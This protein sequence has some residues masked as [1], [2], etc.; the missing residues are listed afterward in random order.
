MKRT[1]HPLALKINIEVLPVNLTSG[2]LLTNQLLWCGC[3]GVTFYSQHNDSLHC[4]L[5]YSFMK[6][7]IVNWKANFIKKRA[8]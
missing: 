7:S 2:I 3:K 5:L 6:D 4:A 8:Y 1:T